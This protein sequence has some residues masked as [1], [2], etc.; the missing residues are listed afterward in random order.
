MSDKETNLKDKLRQTLASTIRII[1]GDLK[2]KQK[3]K[4]NKNQRN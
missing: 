2:I 1:S 3:Y 4:E